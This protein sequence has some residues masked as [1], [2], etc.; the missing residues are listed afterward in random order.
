MSWASSRSLSGRTSPRSTARRSI[1]APASRRGLIKRSVS[2]AARSGE[3]R[4]SVTSD[5]ITLRT[6]GFASTAIARGRARD[7]T[8][9]ARRRWLTGPTSSNTRPHH[10]NLPVHRP[11]PGPE[12]GPTEVSGSLRIGRCRGRRRRLKTRLPRSRPACPPLNCSPTNTCR[13]SSPPAPIMAVPLPAS[14]NPLLA[15][16]EFRSLKG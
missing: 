7:G 11:G 12:S 5:W 3:R 10:P 1:C 9:C 6:R 14:A 2:T 4:A 16:T 8:V 15:R 13:R